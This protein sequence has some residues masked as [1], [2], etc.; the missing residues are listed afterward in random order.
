MLKGASFFAVVCK[1][2]IYSSH[3]WKC[4]R[5][6]ATTTVKLCLP[7][8]VRLIYL[9]R[10]SIIKTEM[11]FQTQT[12]GWISEFNLWSCMFCHFPSFVACWSNIMIWN[13]V[14]SDCHCTKKHILGQI[15]HPS[16][17]PPEQTTWAVTPET[18]YGPNTKIWEFSSTLQSVL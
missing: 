14:I 5:G 13:I 15:T 9:M 2:L 12:Q 8:Y 4:S 17:Q 6:V 3:Q 11:R 10:A 7:F 1:N 16:C 18:V